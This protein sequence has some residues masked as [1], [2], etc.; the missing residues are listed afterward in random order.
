MRW[1]GAI[2]SW[3]L[4]AALGHGL[5]VLA[6]QCQ[7]KALTT[8]SA[9]D[10]TAGEPISQGRFDPRTSRF[11]GHTA[12]RADSVIEKGSCS[13]AALSIH[14]CQKNLCLPDPYGHDV[15]PLVV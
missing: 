12:G 6:G 7:V 10:E 9:P 3:L 14:G 15:A 5:S 2:R 8:K 13:T 4:S 11:S 1:E